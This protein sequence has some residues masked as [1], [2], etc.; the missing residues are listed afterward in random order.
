[1]GLGNNGGFG[2]SCNVLGSYCVILQNSAAQINNSE[3]AVAKKP[4]RAEQFEEN[5]LHLFF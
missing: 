3:Q 4:H 5:I 2:W 1:M